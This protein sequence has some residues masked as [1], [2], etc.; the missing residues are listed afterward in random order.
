LEQLLN[1]PELK[2]GDSMVV[3]YFNS[4]V[5]STAGDLKITFKGYENIATPAGTFSVVKIVVTSE[6]ITGHFEIGTDSSTSTKTL[7]YTI[8][9]EAGANRLIKSTLE[10]TTFVQKTIN[11]TDQSSTDY[12][13][14]ERILI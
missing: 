4:F 5:Y 2:V 7:S 3:P 12:P 8:Y 10:S 13:T 6:N 9:V 14:I 1:K 11:S